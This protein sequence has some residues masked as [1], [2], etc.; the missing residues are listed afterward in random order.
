M[1]K[2]VADTLF[3]HGY[4]C[5]SI[6]LSERN[7]AMEFWWLPL[8]STA[9]GGGLTIIGG[10]V[11]AHFQRKADRKTQAAQLARALRGELSALIRIVALRQYVHGLRGWAAHVRTTQQMQFFMV[12]V[13][14]E[15]RTVFL[16]NAD[17][18]GLLDAT[19]SEAIAVIY[20]QIASVLEDLANFID[21]AT[22]STPLYGSPNELA[23]AYASCADLMDDTLSRAQLA[24]AR[25]DD[26]YPVT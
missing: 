11:A 8:A 26:L 4:K 21:A 24:I 7:M 5:Q 15:Y 13:R 19:L 10:F 23:N 9:L 25:I 6:R 12:R 20:T 3:I 2:K 18:M 22:S 16:K 17:Q 1:P 14:Q